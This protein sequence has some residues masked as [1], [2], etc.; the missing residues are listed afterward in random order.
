MEI[1][2]VQSRI[3]YSHKSQ[4]KSTDDLNIKNGKI[5]MKHESREMFLD[6]NGWTS[7]T[8]SLLGQEKNRAGFLQVRDICC[9][10]LHE[11]FYFHS[12]YP[13]NKDTTKALTNKLIDIMFW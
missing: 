6:I 2:G 10:T 5:H 13:V 4:R 3:K 8:F 7:V 1:K 11:Y 9:D 12:F